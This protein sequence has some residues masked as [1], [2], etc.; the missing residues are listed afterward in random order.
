MHK[1]FRFQFVDTGFAGEIRHL[2]LAVVRTPSG[3]SKRAKTACGRI[4]G[5][6][7]MWVRGFGETQSSN[8]PACI[9]AAIDLNL[10]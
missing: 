8:C 5:E 2:A 9:Q 10:G 6:T 4:Y 7:D 1:S 3:V